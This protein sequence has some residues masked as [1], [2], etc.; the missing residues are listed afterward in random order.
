MLQ[1]EVVAGGWYDPA[2]KGR[3][4]EPQG[5]VQPPFPSF[6][7][8]LQPHRPIRLCQHRPVLPQ[9]G[10]DDDKHLCVS[11]HRRVCALNRPQAIGVGTG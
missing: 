6:M 1:Q 5:G 9:E 8:S 3:W 7:F 2:G 4:S 11:G 10:R